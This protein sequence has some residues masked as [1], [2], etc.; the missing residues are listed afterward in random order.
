MKKK[1]KEKKDGEKEW[2]NQGASRYLR[3]ISKKK[4]VGLGASPS[5]GG[6]EKGE[7]AGGL[8]LTLEVWGIRNSF[9]FSFFFFFLLVFSCDNESTG[10]RLSR[11]NQHDPT[12]N[13]K[14]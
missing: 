11:Q 8:G 14:G 2:V 12:Q 3:D 9:L 7:E 5:G 10:S 6:A 4:S 1:K 13:P